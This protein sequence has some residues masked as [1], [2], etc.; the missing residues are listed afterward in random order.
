MKF[1][2][3]WFV[4]RLQKVAYDH[5]RGYG[6]HGQNQLITMI[7]FSVLLCTKNSQRLIKEVINSVITQ[8]NKVIVEIII[9]DHK[10]TDDTLL[11]ARNILSNTPS[12]NYLEISCEVPGKSPALILGLDAA[13]GEYVIILDDDNV[14]LPDYTQVA[15]EVLRDKNI[16]CVGSQGIFDE[17]LEQP[18]WFAEYKGVYAIGL[19]PQG[20]RTDWVWGASSIIN[21]DAWNKLRESGFKLILNPVRE[22]HVAPIPIGGE[23]VELALAIKLI[24]YE[25]VISERLKFIHKFEQSRLAEEYLLENCRGVT[26]SVAVH[27]I[28][29]QIIYQPNALFPKLSWHYVIARKITGCSIRIVKNYLNGGGLALKYNKAILHGILIG[30]LDCRSQFAIIYK[31]LRILKGNPSEN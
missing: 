7:K 3:S 31:R 13:S 1:E 22:S 4:A 16:G 10:S 12:V 18:A 14:L 11:I 24:G 29:R 27:D 2:K 25:I 21:K 15:V 9:V 19:P 20:E 23:D 8:F 28:Y 30:F 26:R 5:T 17:K 6:L